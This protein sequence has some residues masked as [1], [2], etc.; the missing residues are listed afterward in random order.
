MGQATVIEMCEYLNRYCQLLYERR[1]LNG[2]PFDLTGK[3]AM[4][5]GARAAWASL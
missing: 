4:I 1:I 2:K 3:N 5:I